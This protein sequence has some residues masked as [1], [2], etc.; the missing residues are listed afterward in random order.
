MPAPRLSRLVLALL[1]GISS[2]GLAGCVKP[3]KA[4]VALLLA[5]SQATRWTEVD[6]PVF[7][8]HLEDSCQGCDYVT[9]NAG[10][11]AD[12]QAEQFRDALDDGADVIV[13]NAVDGEEASALV[14]EAGEVPVI[15]YDRF[16]EGADHFVSADPAVIGRMMAQG[17]VDAVGRRSQVLMV[18]GATG[19]DNAAEIREAAMGVFKRHRVKVVAELSP[20]SWDAAS[21]KQFVLEQKGRIGRVDAVLAA[22]DTQASGVVEALEELEVGAR[23]YPFVTGQDAEL[24]AVRRVVAGEQGLTVYKEITTMAQRAA[25]LAID[26]M[27]D[28]VPEDTTDYKGV[29]AVLVEPVVVTRETIARTVVRDGVYSLDDICTDDVMETCEQLALR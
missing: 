4:V 22:N 23:S 14:E 8:Q 17:I 15:A 19:D 28:E 6:Q 25:D 27:L 9:Y 3:D 5:S 16:V 12:K 29:P 26:L 2:L 18:N 10:R 24:T 7:A 20:D 21:A 1:L 13:L 11:D